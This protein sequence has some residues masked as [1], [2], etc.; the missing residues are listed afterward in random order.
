M[1]GSFTSAALKTLIQG[2]EEQMSL[3]TRPRDM[4]V[5]IPRD[6]LVALYNEYQEAMHRH[7]YYE[8]GRTIRLEEN[9]DEV[10]G[11]IPRRY[12]E[13][14]DLGVK[15]RVTIKTAEDKCLHCN[16]LGLHHLIPRGRLAKRIKEHHENADRQQALK[17]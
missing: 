2:I 9:R 11:K 6:V 13:H 7:F 8:L 16:K 15:D 5:S 1:L 3:D 17:V 14:F 10:R 12:V 4:H